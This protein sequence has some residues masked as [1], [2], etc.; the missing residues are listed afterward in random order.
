MKRL[1]SF[2]HAFHS[3]AKLNKANL[4]FVLI[5][6]FVKLTREQKNDVKTRAGHFLF[7][8][9]MCE[10]RIF[11]GVAYIL[12][13]CANFAILQDVYFGPGVSLYLLHDDT[14]HP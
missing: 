12:A 5:Q 10:F 9:K 2:V 7:L 13:L 14:G 3:I 1:R 4:D 8:H 11:Q 6:L